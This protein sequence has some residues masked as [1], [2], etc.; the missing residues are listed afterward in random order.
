MQ[1]IELADRVSK[2]GSRDPI[3]VG[4]FNEAIA[5]RL[6]AKPHSLDALGLAEDP[7][8]PSNRGVR[9]R[10]NQDL[11]GSSELESRGVE[12]LS[13]QTIRLPSTKGVKLAARQNKPP[14]AVLIQDGPQGNVYLDIRAIE[15]FKISDP[16]S[17]STLTNALLSM[18]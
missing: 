7:A 13:N 5:N 18:R 12:S 17:K 3:D 9:H 11:W 15:D 8:E 4:V 1:Y 2:E 10:E 6:A 16:V 14:V